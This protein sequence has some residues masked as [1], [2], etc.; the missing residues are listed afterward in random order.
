MGG[1]H[2]SSHGLESKLKAGFGFLHQLGEAWKLGKFFDLNL[3]KRA[4]GQVGLWQP[5]KMGRLVWEKEKHYL[6]SMF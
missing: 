6:V 1:S 4:V 2:A 5:W 3:P